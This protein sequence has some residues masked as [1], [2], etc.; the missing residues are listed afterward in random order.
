MEL[1]TLKINGKKLLV[2]STF[3]F[4]KARDGQYIVCYNGR[5]HYIVGGKKAGGRA[6]EWFVDGF[7]GAS[8]PVCGP[9]EA[10][11]LIVGA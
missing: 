10:V 9:V 3:N 6:N 1:K 7:G 8:I 5:S 11:K 4:R 2:P